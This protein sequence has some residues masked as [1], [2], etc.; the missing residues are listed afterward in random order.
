MSAA[1][2]RGEKTET[3]QRLPPELGRTAWFLKKLSI[4]TGKWVPRGKH[5]K[6]LGREPTCER[7]FSAGS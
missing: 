1:V 6:S 7:L 3:Q 2:P 5:V 4:I